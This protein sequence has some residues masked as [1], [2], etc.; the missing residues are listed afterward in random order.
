[1][2]LSAVISTWDDDANSYTTG[3][4]R[5]ELVLDD[6]N[7]KGFFAQLEGAKDAI[8]AELGALGWHNPENTKQ[9]R[10]FTKRAVNMEQRDEWPD[11]FGWLQAR[12]E[13]FREVLGPQVKALEVLS[14][15]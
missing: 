14:L 7:A 15:E 6:Q 8:E 10:I 1:M 2:H 12:L 4:N 11:Q 9:C 5:V 3:L 13:R